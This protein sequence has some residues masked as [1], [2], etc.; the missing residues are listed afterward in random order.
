MPKDRSV[1]LLKMTM[2]E[3]YRNIQTDIHSYSL[4]RDIGI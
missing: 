1:A 2:I 4:F 3:I